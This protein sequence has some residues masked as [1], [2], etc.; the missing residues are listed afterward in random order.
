[1]SIGASSQRLTLQSNPMVRRLLLV[2]LLAEMGYAVLN[3]SAMPMYLTVDRNFGA[4]TAA[5]ALV[6]F[7]LSEA[8]FK[9]PMGH[10]ADRYGRKTL[11]M[12]GPLFTVCTSL[13]TLAVPHGAGWLEVI[14]L[15][16]LRVFDGVGAAMIWPAAFALMSDCVEDNQRQ[17]A[18]SLLNLCYL[19][20]VALALPMGGLVNDLTASKA[21]SLYLA[22]GLF[23]SVVAMVR[24]RTP[25]EPAHAAAS[26][27][28]HGAF[29]VADM[30]SA[31][32]QIPQY[33][34]LTLVTFI[35]I[36][37]PMP[38]IKIFASDVFRMTE[39]QFGFFVVLPGALAMAALSM[40]MSKLGESLGR[41]RAVHIGLFL[42]A[43]GMAFIALGGLVPAL[44]SAWAMAVGGVP[45]GL[46]FLLAIPAWMASVSDLNAKRRA[47]NLG[48][49]MTAQG[50]GAILGAWVGGYLYEALPHFDPA[51]GRYSP[52]LGCATCVA[53][54]WL[55]SLK[56]LR[57]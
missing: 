13:L 10:L 48:A 25:P 33:L 31:A 34:A 11:M 16:V 37:F 4:S 44:R 41:A 26:A 27:E 50:L 42:C 54:G 35:G 47:V 8:V 19:L 20:G 43:A 24:F 53:A 1:M 3:I 2:A 21:A 56:V 7:L 38:V 23:A 57:K 22:A 17:Q 15:L 6:A 14:L 5:I 55:L 49:V 36:G 28:E 18:M 52:F 12:L 45:V 39:T 9:G 51:L 30:V 40:P 29:K 32:K 46:G